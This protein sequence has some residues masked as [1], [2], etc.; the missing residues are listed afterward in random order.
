M[1]RLAFQR[2]KV[3]RPSTEMLKGIA[4]VKQTVR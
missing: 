2:T 3:F 1:R 4:V